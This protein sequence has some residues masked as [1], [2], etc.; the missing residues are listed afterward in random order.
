M[1]SWSSF[2][3]WRLANLVVVLANG[4]GFTGGATGLGFRVVGILFDSWD[5]DARRR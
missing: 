1:R 4:G 2:E 3:Q 5:L